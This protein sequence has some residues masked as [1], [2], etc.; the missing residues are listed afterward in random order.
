MLELLRNTPVSKIM[1]TSVSIPSR[2]ELLP[3]DVPPAQK[4]P[5]L[6]TCER[7]DPASFSRKKLRCQLE[8]VILAQD[9]MQH[10]KST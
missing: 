8:T 6:A 2:A 7:T 4:H 5:I 10:E 9:N 3:Q 1:W